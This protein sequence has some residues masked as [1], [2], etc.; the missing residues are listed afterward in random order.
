M[1]KHFQQSTKQT[2]QTN[3]IKCNTS[4]A[5][6]FSFSN[7]LRI[8][9]III[10]VSLLLHLNSELFWFFFSLSRAICFSFGFSLA[11]SISGIWWHRCSNCKKWNPFEYAYFIG[12]EVGLPIHRRKCSFISRIVVTVRF[13]TVTVNSSQK[14]MPFHN[15]NASQERKKLHIKWNL[16]YTNRMVFPRNMP[17]WFAHCFFYIW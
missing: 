11:K 1:L 12:L 15:S 14:V 4:A 5:W 16:P 8:S 17:S 6:K 9:I 2:Y 7:P 3:H 13:K 10:D